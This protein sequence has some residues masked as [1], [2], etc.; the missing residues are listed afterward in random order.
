MNFELELEQDRTVSPLHG[1]KRVGYNNGFL[2]LCTLHLAE[3][4]S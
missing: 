4:N 1:Y 2:C 3:V